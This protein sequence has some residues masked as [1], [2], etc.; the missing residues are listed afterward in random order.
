M[1]LTKLQFK[2]GVNREGTNYSNEGGWYESDKIRFRSGYPEKIGGWINLATFTSGVAST[3][4]GVARSLWNW[5]T[6]SF[7]NL[8]AIG[9]NCKLYIEYGGVYKDITP[10]SGTAVAL[11]N[12][13]F[14]TTSG[15]RLITV[16]H[17]AHGRTAGT[18]VTFA[19]ASTFNG[20]T[21]TGEYEIISLPT[22]N[23][24]TIAYSSTASGTG[25]GGGASV[26]AHYE[27]N[28]GAASYSANNGWGAGVWGR[29]AWGSGSTLG[30]D[31]QL[32]LWTM[33]NYGQ[34]LIAAPRNGVIYYWAADTSTFA[35]AVT[36]ES[37]VSAPYDPDFVPNQTLQVL[38]SDT[39]RFVIC[40]GANPY[41]PGDSETDF[42]PM[43]VRWSDQENAYEWV[44]AITNQAGELR[45]SIGSTIVTGLQMRQENLVFTDSALY[46]MQ[47]LG[48]PYVWGFNL[49]TGNISIISPNCVTTAN[50]IAYWMGTDKFYMYSGRVETLPCT[51]RQYVF[52][53]L[54]QD[55]AYQIVCGT[56]ESFSEVWWFYPSLNSTVND[57]YVIYNYLENTWYYGSLSRTAWSDS[58]LRQYPMGAYSVKN[59]YLNE[60]LDSSDTTVTITDATTYPL[61][62]AVQID[63]EIITYTGISGNN[64]TGCVRGADGTT[65]ASHEQ[66][67]PVTC[68][69]PNQIMYHEYGVDDA[70][71]QPA[72]PIEAYIGSSDFDIGDGHNFG[73]VWRIIPDMTFNGSTVN[74]PSV[75]MTVRPRQFS[76]SAYGEPDPRDIDSTQNYV[77]QRNY[78]VQQYTGQVYTRLRGRQMSFKIASDTLGVNWQLGVPRIDIRADGKR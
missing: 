34:D 28:A 65:A 13:P 68:H 75:T 20:V 5:V 78:D 60:A 10:W 37:L 16:T 44:P 11:A 45:L 12:D 46:V 4:K 58:S 52:G 32:R 59:A 71:N 55:Q 57:R 47:Y 73:F 19:G 17:T 74:Q 69:I 6:L 50:N 70:S 24:Y 63:S 22:V 49:I 14:A 38:V 51:L 61:E 35:R 36:L 31:S 77:G 9:T 48:P 26:T 2:P 18:Y 66:Y 29:G 53:D 39:Q 1:P 8:N 23:S 7:D 41:D 30:F 67:T 43:L 21:I 3:F 42:D 54:N 72:V 15:S 27:I 33:D 25:S 40:F 76:G 56:N 62:G 64:L